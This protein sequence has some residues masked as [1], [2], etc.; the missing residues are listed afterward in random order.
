MHKI[1]SYISI[2]RKTKKGNKEDDPERQ[3][4]FD[5]LTKQKLKAG[6]SVRLHKSSLEL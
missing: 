4:M 3:D 1:K 6:C 5:G 2:K